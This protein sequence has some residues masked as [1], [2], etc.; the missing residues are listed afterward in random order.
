ME[1][2]L[3]NLLNGISLGFI[4]FLI[5]SGF[6][7]IFGTMEIL[8]L[9][10]GSLFM[11]GA[12]T[13][14]TAGRFGVNFVFAALIGGLGALVADLA[15]FGFVRYLFMDEIIKNLEEQIARIKE[16]DDDTSEA[17]WQYQVGVLLSADE[18]QKIIDALKHSS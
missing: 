10:H 16:Y 3:V 4:L 6:S 17:S 18:A 15:I 14:I 8:N 12:Y 9:T 11:I 2:W 1:D 5:A 13:G 7:L